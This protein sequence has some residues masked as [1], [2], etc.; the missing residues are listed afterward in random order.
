[1]GRKGGARGR[2]ELSGNMESG[3]RRD[4]AG[5]YATRS[6]GLAQRASESARRERQSSSAQ[7]IAQRRAQIEVGC[8]SGWGWRQSR[9]VERACQRAPSSPGSGAGRYCGTR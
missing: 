2:R 7:R 1:M 6:D 3:V 9:T 8:R 4:E 5:C